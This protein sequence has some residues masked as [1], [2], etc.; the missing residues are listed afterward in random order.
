L[1]SRDH[2]PAGGKHLLPLLQL[3]IPGIDM[4]DPIKTIAS[5]M[6]ITSSLMTVPIVDLTTMDAS[7]GDDEEDYSDQME[8]IDNDLCG[9]T[10]PK[11]MENRL[12]R[13]AT[14][15]F[16]EWL[17]KFIQ[18]IFTIFENMPQHDRKKQGGAMEAGLTQMVL[19]ST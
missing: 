10:F 7:K 18:R 14:G 9:A 5:L 12:C 6:F 15:E 11:G 19:V 17:T 1:F 16:Q 3:A 4:N 13:M 2:Y 8:M